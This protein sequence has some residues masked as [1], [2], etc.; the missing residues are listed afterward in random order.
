MSLEIHPSLAK[1]F[2]DT[3]THIVIIAASKNNGIVMIVK[4]TL[5]VQC[6]ISFIIRFENGEKTNN[7]GFD[8]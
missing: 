1:V 2:S 6:A 8:S 4:L 3:M 5:F 7:P